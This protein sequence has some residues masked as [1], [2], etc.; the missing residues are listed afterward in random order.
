MAWSLPAG[1]QLRPPKKAV[2]ATNTAGPAHAH[3]TTTPQSISTQAAGDNDLFTSA[4]ST[5]AEVTV[6]APP[7]AMDAPVDCN[8]PR[9]EAPE[10]LVAAAAQPA[11][12]AA[13]AQPA[14]TG[15]LPTANPVAYDSGMVPVVD[16]SSCHPAPVVAQTSTVKSDATGGMAAPQQ[17]DENDSLWKEVTDPATGKVYY[18][19]CV[20]KESVWTKPVA[21]LETGPSGPS[22]WDR[23]RTTAAVTSNVTSS[24]WTSVGGAAKKLAQATAAT[25]SSSSS[26]STPAAPAAQSAMSGSLHWDADK[27]AWVTQQGVAPQAATPQGEMGWVWNGT[28]WVWQLKVGHPGE[29]SNRQQL[30]QTGQHQSGVAGAPAPIVAPIAD[31]SP[32]AGQGSGGQDLGPWQR[33]LAPDG[34]S[35]WWNGLTGESQWHAPTAEQIRK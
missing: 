29:Q 5:V 26:S 12:V 24:I 33:H 32:S 10:P 23:L 35:Y 11:A 6:H 20:T 28:D 21:L 9:A 2:K 22:F 8:K 25:A 27:R 18:Y 1:A 34:Q 30:P 17:G 3:A 13:A 7:V 16:A 31:A 15:G 19:H 14:A 4:G